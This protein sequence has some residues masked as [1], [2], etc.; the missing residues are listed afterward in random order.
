MKNLILLFLAMAL[1]PIA[2]FAQG[3]Y[4]EADK[5]TLRAFLSQPSAESGETNG[6]RL[7]LTTEDMETWEEDEDW[8][9]N[10]EGLLWEIDESPKRIVAIDWR[11]KG[12][13]GNLDL[14]ECT[15]LIDL[16]CFVNSLTAL[17]VSNAAL[18]GLACGN[19]QLTTLDVS[20]TLRSLFCGNNRLTELNVNANTALT[21][22]DCSNNKLTT[23]DVSANTALTEL[24]C[25]NNQ[26]TT[27]DVRANTELT[28]LN[29]NGNQLKELE[30]SN[31]TAL[32]RLYCDNNELKELDVSANTDLTNLVCFNNELTTLDVSKNT[33]LTDLRC[34]G[35][36]L[37]DVTVGWTTIPAMDYL[38]IYD[39]SAA[40]LHV[41]AGTKALYQAADVWKDFGRIVEEGE[42]YSIYH[43]SD[44]ATL[45]AFL[46]QPSAES[47][48]TN[49]ERLG[50]TTE[51]METWEADEDWVEKV[52]GLTWNKESPKRVVFIS[53]SEKGLAGNL[54]LSGCEALTSLICYTNALTAL[55]VS[56][57]TALTYLECSNNELTV[58]DVRKNMALT[59]LG[60]SNNPL[61]TLDVSANTALTSL[62]CSNNELTVLNVRKNTALTYLG[63]YT[64]ELTALDVSANTALTSLNC[65]NN[66]LTALDVSANTALT[67][68]NCSNNELTALDV[69]KNTELT[70]LDCDYNQ[71]KELD[72]SANT[73]LI[74]LTCPGNPLTDVTVGW[75]TIPAMEYLYVLADLSAATLHVPADTKTLYEEAD[76]WKDFGT[77]VEEGEQYSIYHE[78]D[79]ATLRAFLSQPSAE[80]GETNGER[81]GLTTEDMETWETDEDWVEKV[82]GLSWD[83]ESPKRVINIDWYEK[84]LAG[85][86]D[87]SG[88][89]ALINLSCYSNELTTLDVNANTALTV[90]R[91][92]DNQLPSLDVSA[93]TA[94]TTLNCLYNQ[95]TDLDVSH[96]TALTHLYCSYN[97]LTT[98]DV[99]ANK[100]LVNLQ[101]SNNQLTDLDVSHHTALSLLYCENNQ[102]TTLDVSHSTVTFWWG[103]NFRSNPLTDVTVGS[104]PPNNV[105]IDDMPLSS[106]TLHVPAGTKALYQAADVWKDFGTI[107]EYGEQYS[108]YHEADKATL[109]AFLEQ[110]SAE[111]GQTNGE[112]LGLTTEDM[113][114]WEADEDWVEKVAGLTWNDESP[115]RVVGIKWGQ[116]GLDGNLDLSGCTALT[117]LVCSYNSLS[118]LVVNNN[119]ALTELYCESSQLW[120]LD[121]S[122]NAALTVL[123]CGYNM[124]NELDVSNNTALTS[125]S[126]YNN[127]LKELEISNHTA[128]TYLGCFY[129]QLTVLDVS[130]NTALTDL[131]C[132]NNKL[133]ALDVRTNTAL[134]GLS[135]SDNPLTDVTVGWTTIPAM[136]SLSV[137]ADV[138]STTLHV[139]AGTKALYQAADVWKDFG[140]IVEYGTSLTVN[141]STLD[142]PAD[143]GSQEIS[144]TSNT[145]WT[146]S[147][148][149]L[150]ATVSPASGSNDD[151]VS[152]TVTTN[153]GSSERTATITITGGGIT[154]T[155]DVTQAAAETPPPAA[156][157]DVSTYTQNF[158]A[159]GGS[160][161]LFVTSNTSWTVSSSESWATVYPA[162]GSNDETVRVT[163]TAN[164]GGERTATITITGG[165]ITCTVDV[166]QAEK[167]EPKVVVT[168]S[169][170]AG[171]QG[172]IDVSLS[173][174]EDE[175]ITSFTFDLTLPDGFHLNR[176]A[177]ALDAK[178]VADYQL[179]ITEKTGNSWSFDISSKALRS[180]SSAPVHQKLVDVAYTVDESVENSDYEITISN[181]LFEGEDGTVIEEDEIIATVTTGSPVG[182]LSP[183]QAAVSVY[184]SHGVLT[185]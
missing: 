104:T 23:L 77:I 38:F 83:E 59:G 60:C 173:F 66:A 73:A 69:R 183:R 125:L 109:R 151:E 18:M 95:L 17:D 75:T 2:G 32:A 114:T 158:P 159:D 185:V 24:I 67:M 78:A 42:Q 97:A 21:H 163:A 15:A 178:L 176:E 80:S 135:C 51:D 160:L 138:S 5:A 63:C 170:P 19:N 171:N 40:T 113:E 143:G 29:C 122:N 57:N 131:Y 181:L 93:N 182:I 102:L 14:S 61:G 98:L 7:G 94:L 112:R 99:S 85:N 134:T 147:S 91:C 10:V 25:Y 150:W 139:P 12:L 128:L 87:L 81:L 105:V 82:A 166:T 86:L 28:G 154:R 9:G 152:V 35:N 165:G 8:V 96:N 121:V 84:G 101:C 136:E 4:H 111:S 110:P 90:L 44:K 141:P 168:P 39:V 145:S 155:V 31:N 142:F 144:V 137:P 88:C 164:D 53:W 107:V 47:G 129:N 64:N 108:I 70:R 118:E 3:S 106:I 126:C 76:V 56:A 49:G 184:Y 34:T 33:A 100:V 116:K 161:Y 50:L 37:T 41:P 179:T 92:A 45:R 1:L 148:S 79:K 20:V 27:L 169:E 52:A 115:K 127:S 167:E 175:A 132:S 177:T 162:S 120:A 30:V 119:T 16:I 124:L 48:Q 133:T 54:D 36:P 11:E 153:T 13:A 6:E 43:E 71:L 26:L 180:A 123:S 65:Y 62:N 22:L 103:L 130:N 156:T 89:E 72:V 140:T 146:A 74:Q 46:S 55:D 174:P 117:N 172:T 68:L 58:L 157:L 149:E